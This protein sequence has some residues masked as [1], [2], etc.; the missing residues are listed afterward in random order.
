MTMLSSD[1]THQDNDWYPR[2]HPCH[3]HVL[4]P[5]LSGWILQGVAIVPRASDSDY[6]R[7]RREAGGRKR[8]AGGR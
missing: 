3:V 8:E 2:R 4:S 5:T 7:F 1:P 6:G